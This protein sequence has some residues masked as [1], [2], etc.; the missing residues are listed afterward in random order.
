MTTL[1]QTTLCLRY[2]DYTRSSNV[3]MSR[4]FTTF[5]SRRLKQTKATQKYCLTSSKDQQRNQN[6]LPAFMQTFKRKLLDNC[7]QLKTSDAFYRTWHRKL[8]SRKDDDTVTRKE[9]NDLKKKMEGMKI[10]LLA[11]KARLFSVGK[12]EEDRRNVESLTYEQK[13]ED[14]LEAFNR[15]SV[16]EADSDIIAKQ[17]KYEE[18][19]L[20]HLNAFKDNSVRSHS[21]SSKHVSDNL[22]LECIADASEN[23]NKENEIDKQSKYEQVM[24]ENLSAFKDNSVH[25]HTCSSKHLLD[26]LKLEYI[27][28]AGGNLNKNTC[29]KIGLP[30]KDANDILN[31]KSDDSKT[32]VKQ[33]QNKIT[34]VNIVPVSDAELKKTVHSVLKETHFNLSL[35]TTKVPKV[36]V[37]F[38]KPF[39]KTN[40]NVLFTVHETTKK[41][42]TCLKSSPGEI[43]QMLLSKDEQKILKQMIETEIRKLRISC[44]NGSNEYKTR[45]NK[46]DSKIERDID[47]LSQEILVNLMAQVLKHASIKHKLNRWTEWIKK[48]K[49]QK[50]VLKKFFSLVVFILRFKFLAGLILPDA[51]DSLATVEIISSLTMG[52]DTKVEFKSTSRYIVLLR[53]VR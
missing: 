17:L 53:R 11:V 31:R 41:R 7:K 15:S 39:K 20:E 12:K 30:S 5:I 38:R 28:D 19:M 26:N 42:K 51:V 10:R 50:K 49:N 35:Q 47:I 44:E 16:K 24:F 37:G 6:R 18:V 23:L 2:M 36:S 4:N 25:S 43:L 14:A 52:S 8:C 21:C 13:L 33:K 46:K 27:A 22:K 45:F 29:I 34:N 48:G 32:S 3:L 1:R 9:T 40:S